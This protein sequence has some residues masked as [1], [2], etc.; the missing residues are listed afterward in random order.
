[1]ILLQRNHS[2]SLENARCIRDWEICAFQLNTQTLGAVKLCDSVEWSSNKLLNK[3]ESKEEK[4]EE[5]R[6]NHVYPIFYWKCLVS[7]LLH[8][9]SVLHFSFST[10]C[11]C[12]RSLGSVSIVV[13]LCEAIFFER[14]TSTIEFACSATNRVCD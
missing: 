4:E 7:L 9:C 13:Y 1:M 3:I 10:I 6:L 5:M 8:V 12:D 14:I 11:A 2:L